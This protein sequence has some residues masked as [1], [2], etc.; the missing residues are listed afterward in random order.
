M[1]RNLKDPSP[2]IMKPRYEN[3][4]PHHAASSKSLAADKK[5]PTFAKEV[6]LRTRL[7]QS[8]QMVNYNSF[9]HNLTETI[10]AEAARLECPDRAEPLAR[11]PAP[12]QLSFIASATRKGQTHQ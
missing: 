10:F 2:L 11:D 8:P 3:I 4:H 7:E 5:R 12:T 1:P 6:A 9:Q